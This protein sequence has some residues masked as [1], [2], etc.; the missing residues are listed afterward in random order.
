MSRLGT[1]TLIGDSIRL[2]YEPVVRHLLSDVAY[3]WGP[4]ENCASTRRILANAD[5]WLV[6][7]AGRGDVVHLNAGLHDLRRLPETAGLP[8]VPLDE[9]TQNLES[10]VA[11]LLAGG[12]PGDRIVL[13][14]STPVD[15]RRHA[16]GRVSNRHEHDVR[17]YN[18]ALIDV[19]DRNGVAVN[20]LHEVVG[21]SIGTLLGP[22]GVHLSD[23]G[24]R[25]AGS[26]VAAAL[27]IRF[28]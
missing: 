3:V 26:A 23:A 24:N 5:D 19:A 9:Y 27:R 8:E 11:I 25:A 12:L 10:I 20:H 14:T 6:E 16:E 18:A 7:P 2:G 15:Q 22:D 17:A 13:A 21:K 1:A 4:A 28:D